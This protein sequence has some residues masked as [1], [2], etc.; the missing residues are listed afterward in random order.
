MEELHEKIKQRDGFQGRIGTRPRIG[1]M[2]PGQGSQKLNMGI[3]LA[4]QF[5]D[6]FASSMIREDIFDAVYPIP[7]FS[8][9]EIHEQRDRLNQTSMAQPALAAVNWFYYQV[10]EAF[11][12]R[13]DV[14]CGH[15]FGEYVAIAASG[16]M[17]IEILI[18]VA[19][20]RGKLADE[21]AKHTPMRMIAVKASETKV[22]ETLNAFMNQ[23]VFI[24]N[25][26]GDDQIVIAV[27]ENAKDNVIETLKRA[28]LKYV[29][30]QVTSASIF[31]Y[32]FQ[33]KNNFKNIFKNSIS[34]NHH[35][36]Y[37]PMLQ[38]VL[39]EIDV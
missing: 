21:F 25:I 24:A 17:N 22:L 38:C 3:D 7:T 27:A 18:E 39:M 4:L 16:V 1:F 35:F 14:A 6:L 9:D 29:M 15:S 11:H 26:N 19:K 12:V 8:D 20:M 36:Q 28:E 31:R 30:L 32:F 33:L 2:F 34:K 13:P 10:L 37:I 5:P 23:S